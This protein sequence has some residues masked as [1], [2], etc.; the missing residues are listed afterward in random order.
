MAFIEVIGRSGRA[1]REFFR[2]ARF[3]E[4]ARLIAF[5]EEGW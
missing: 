3:G 2:C 4:E 5:E 1:E